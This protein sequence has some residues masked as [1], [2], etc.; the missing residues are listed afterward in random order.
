MDPI[1]LKGLARRSL[2]A[3]P[4]D[5]DMR[6]SSNRNLNV[7]CVPLESFV[8]HPAS[9]VCT[10]R[11]N[12]ERQSKFVIGPSH[13]ATSPGGSCLPGYV[14]TIG[15]KYG[16]G[17]KTGGIANVCPAG[18]FCPAGSKNSILCPVGKFS[19]VEGLKDI[20]GCQSCTRGSYCDT[21]GLTEP[22][23]PIAQ[24][25]YGS[26]GVTTPRPANTTC[27]IG[28]P[29]AW[30]SCYIPSADAVC[31]VITFQ[32]KSDQI[33]LSRTELSLLANDGCPLSNQNMIWYPRR[34]SLL[35]AWFHF[36]PL[37]RGRQICPRGRLGNLHRLPC[38]ILLRPW[39][40]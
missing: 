20:S 21:A 1:V 36:P 6:L 2:F 4:G 26:F 13:G 33:V 29:P 34:R 38:R 11:Q 39:R 19:A 17:T 24:G 15:S 12:C 5:L 27:P 37:M 14:C 7:L 30:Y 25:Y 28:T 18:S 9:I 10:R 31:S 3:L 8:S 22:T 40:Q 35:S 23:G 16:N 32:K